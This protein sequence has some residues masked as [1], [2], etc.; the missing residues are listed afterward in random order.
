MWSEIA[1]I[2][3]LEF[4]SLRFLISMAPL[5]LLGLCLT[6]LLI[7]I[8]CGLFGVG[9]GFLLTPA[10]RSLFDIPYPLAVGSSLLLL[11]LSSLIAS[12]RHWRNGKVDIHMGLILAAGALGGT[13]AG[14][15]LQNLMRGGKP[16]KSFGA[17]YPLLDL[18]LDLLFLMLLGGVAAYILVES[19]HV[20]E[21]DGNKVSS[22]RRLETVGPAPLLSFPRSEVPCFSLWVLLGLGIAI[23]VLTGLMGMGGGFINLPLLIHVIGVPTHIAVGTGVI[24]ILLASGFGALRHGLAGDVDL[25]L[26]G[27]LFA[28]SFFGVQLGVRI[29]CRMRG[30]NIRRYF[31]VVVIAAILVVLWGMAQEIL[32]VLNLREG[33]TKVKRIDQPGMTRIGSA[34]MCFRVVED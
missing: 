13:E 7:G 19:S 27:T 34:R 2:V 23:G 28:G 15:R 30:R 3:G 14:V 11:F 12:F 20:S 18:V 1:S 8:L 6:G 9:G 26:V 32:Y 16:I 24:Q 25:L 33:M 4:G 31:V 29:S 5:W 21:S 22:S 17:A 10:L